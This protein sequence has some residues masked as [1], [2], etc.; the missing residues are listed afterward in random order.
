MINFVFGKDYFSY[1]VQQKIGESLGLGVGEQR[2]LGDK[3]VGC[4]S[5]FSKR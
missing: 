2:I 3:L 1:Y 5:G 4:C